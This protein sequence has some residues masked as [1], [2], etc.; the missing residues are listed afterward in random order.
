MTRVAIY[1]EGA[2]VARAWTES[3]LEQLW[4]TLA[5]RVC[6]ATQ[7]EVIGI[8]KGHIEHLKFDPPSAGEKKKLATNVIGIDQLVRD[9]HSVNPLENVI[10]AFD[11]KPAI[12]APDLA[13]KGRCAEIEWLLRRMIHRRVLPEPFLGAAVA[14][15][16]MY[17]ENPTTPRGSGRPPRLALE[18]L[19]MDPC[20]EALFASDETTVRTATGHS[21]YP[22]DWPKFDSRAQAPER[23]FLDKATKLATGKA[24][25]GI[26]GSYLAA[27][28]EWGYRFLTSAGEN[29]RLL[30]HP[31]AARLGTLL[32]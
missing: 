11:C 3:P 15:Q 26:P 14:L 23:T 18:V 29:A 20:F 27:R 22:K 30:R 2:A 1:A 19:F 7:V 4:K 21:R 16:T 8:S 6:K 13:G 9:R 17:A 25:A 31:I 10:I 28:N 12:T 5:A 24:H 32:V